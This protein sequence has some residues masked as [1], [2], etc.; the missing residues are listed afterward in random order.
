MSLRASYIQCRT[1]D[2]SRATLGEDGGDLDFFS[3]EVVGTVS[4]N[5]L[6]V[7]RWYIGSVS[8]DALADTL[9]GR[10]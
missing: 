2:L 7:C 4:A 6:V 1:K 3:Y 8:A 9:I 5:T 10:C